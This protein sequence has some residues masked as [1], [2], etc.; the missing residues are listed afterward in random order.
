[1]TAFDQQDWACRCEW[2]FG[3][4]RALAP[5]GVI[6][7]VD[8]LSFSTCVDVAVARGAEIIPLGT[9][10]ASAEMF[11][12]AH[13]AELA[14]PR[15]KTRYSLS[16]ASF[17]DISPG[18]RCVLPSPNGAALSLAA[19]SLGCPVL[20]GCFRNARAI[21]EAAQVLGN[22]YNVCPAGEQWAD[23]SLRPALE[24]W[25]AAGAILASL[26]GTKSPEAAAAIAAYESW[27]DDVRE[28]LATTSS[29][30]ELAQ[31]GFATDID[32]AGVVDVSSAVPRLTGGAYRAGPR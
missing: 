15:S 26:P 8:V 24:D 5:C 16:P 9:R 10:D 3:G 23:G 30:R 13:R 29:G 12:V 21:A 18:L 14:G 4:L 17:L 2:G 25:V 11:A 20:T 32:L 1:M 31:R 19:T 22:T 6:I 28:R 7:I 27:A